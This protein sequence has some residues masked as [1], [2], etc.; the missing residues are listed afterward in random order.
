MINVTIA[1][2]SLTEDDTALQVVLEQLQELGKVIGT[3]HEIKED[4]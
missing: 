2:R 4:I 1:V 3:S